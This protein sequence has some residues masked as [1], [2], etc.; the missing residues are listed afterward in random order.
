MSKAK[1]TNQTK[2]SG[3]SDP[4]DK[5][6]VTIAK[7]EQPKETEKK[8]RGRQATEGEPL[9]RLLV[10]LS[11]NDIDALRKKAGKGKVSTKVRELVKEY[12][13]K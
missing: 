4:K 6:K 8:R 12:L 2:K 3:S 7:A 1:A 10:F 13:S 11:P 9:Q 5:K